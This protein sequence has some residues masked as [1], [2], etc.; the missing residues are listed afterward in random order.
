MPRV[1]SREV[2]EAEELLEK[3]MSWSE[4]EVESMPKFYR[5]KAQEYRRLVNLGDG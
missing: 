4:D 3:V 1:A 2:F 5:E